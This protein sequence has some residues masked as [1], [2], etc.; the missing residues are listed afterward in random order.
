MWDI[1]SQR[2]ISSLKGHMSAC[3]SIAPYSAEQQSY[4]ATGSFDCNLK[5]WDLRRKACVQTFKGHRGPVNVVAFSPDSRWVVSGGADGTVKLW[6]LNAGKKLTELALGESPVTCVKFN[7][8]D[9]TLAAGYQDRTV[10]YWD[11]ETFGHISTTS[12]DPTPIQKICFQPDNGRLLFSA[13]NESLK[14][15]EIEHATVLDNVESSWRGVVDLEVNMKDHLLVG[16]CISGT[17]LSLWT[18]D[19]KS[20]SSSA[21]EQKVNPVEQRPKKREKVQDC[22]VSF[23]APS[24]TQPLGLDLNDFMP[25]PRFEAT[26]E[27]VL[28]EIAEGH[29]SILAVVARR[30]ES[31]NLI[32]N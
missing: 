3:S 6:D 7:P 10:K 27:K 14:L 19:L 11:L 16:L 20:V 8:E 13:S 12:P 32:Y 31:L 5:L 17:S 4:L 29:H 21:E 1:N 18:T 22:G 15:W 9:M 26:E 25:K 23:I 28:S 24:G 30:T 2:P